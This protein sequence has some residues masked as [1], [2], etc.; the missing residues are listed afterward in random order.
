[1]SSDWQNYL[2]LLGSALAAGTINAVA[3]GGTLLTFPALLHV[4][5]PVLANATSTVA[6]V[7]GSLAGTWG[8]RHEIRQC[9][10]WLVL[11]APSCVVG[12]AIGSLLVTRLPSIYFERLV[13]WLILAA[14]LLFMAQPA[15]ARLI[16][17][18]Q[19][20]RHPS[21]SMQA[22]LIVFQLF[23]AIYGGYFGAGIGILMLGAL[24]MMGLGDI[25][26]MNAVKTL[27]AALINAVSVVVFVLDDKVR[28]DFGLSMAVAAVI[29]GYLGARVAR[30]LDRTLVRWVVIVIGLSMAGFYFY[31]Q[32]T[33]P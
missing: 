31:R 1:M 5:D 16:G 32:W 22:S 6:L 10:Y 30:R 4:L 25:H 28:W 21:Q 12:G 24:G 27:L 20:Q 29:G 7:P 33:G 13:P 8:Y 23:V 3:G 18:T 26:R 15:I 17:I 14:A 2:L 9:K 11:L 19:E